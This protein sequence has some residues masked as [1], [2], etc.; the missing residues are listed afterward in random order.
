M[1]SLF[2]C[3]AVRASRETL[4]FIIINIYLFAPLFTDNR[5][6]SQDSREETHLNATQPSGNSEQFNL[7]YSGTLKFLAWKASG[8]PLFLGPASAQK[9]FTISVT[10]N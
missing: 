6:Q 2:P 8:L 1:A 3:V 5:T 4:A 10:R 9:F 7:L